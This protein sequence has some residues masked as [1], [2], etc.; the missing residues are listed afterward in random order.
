[1]K[2]FAVGKEDTR[3]GIR[4]WPERGQDGGSLGLSRTP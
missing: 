3:G 2:S 4:M 1:M